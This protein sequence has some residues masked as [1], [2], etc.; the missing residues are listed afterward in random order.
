M[1]LSRAGQKHL[2]P[3]QPSCR[4]RAA[5]AIELFTGHATHQTFSSSP[6][7]NEKVI[8][9]LLEKSVAGSRIDKGNA[10]H[11]TIVIVGSA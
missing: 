10:S 4:T 11:Y 7:F 2:D 6:L 3:Y 9:G 8:S 1:C 5:M